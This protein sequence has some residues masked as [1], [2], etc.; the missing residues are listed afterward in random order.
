M[1]KLCFIHS[2]QPEQ[3]EAVQISP[4]DNLL[5][6][7]SLNTYSKNRGLSRQL[8]QERRRARKL[9]QLQSQRQKQVQRQQKHQQKQIN[10]ARKQNKKMKNQRGGNRTGINLFCFYFFVFI[11]VYSLCASYLYFGEEAIHIEHFP[12]RKVYFT[13]IL[14]KKSNKIELGYYN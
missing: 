6:Q 10:K 3:T 8:R 12:N 9:R 5:A 7:A 14:T 1:Y 11:L 13:R 2:V 4:R